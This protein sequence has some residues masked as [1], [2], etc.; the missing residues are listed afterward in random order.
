MT[1]SDLLDLELWLHH[2]TAAAV[3]V[4]ADGERSKAVWL[5]KSAIEIERRNGGTVLVAVPRNLA[6]DKGLC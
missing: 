2:E 5:P 3:L 6:I 1:R 4:S